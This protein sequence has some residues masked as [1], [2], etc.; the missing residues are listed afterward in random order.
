MT[1]G[2]RSA[3]AV[4]RAMNGAATDEDITAIVGDWRFAQVAALTPGIDPVVH[5]LAA[6][7][8]LLPSLMDADV[9]AGPVVQSFMLRLIETSAQRSP[10]RVR[11]MLQACAAAAPGAWSGDC[12]QAIVHAVHQNACDHAVAASLI[13]PCDRSARLLGSPAAA[14]GAVR[15]WG[16]AGDGATWTQELSE[17]MRRSVIDILRNAPHEMVH[18]L[19]W[20]PR[21][22]VESFTPP[23][24]SLFGAFDAFALASDPVRRAHASVIARLI[25][26]AGDDGLTV[27]ALVRFAHAARSDAAWDQV[28]ASMKRQPAI[29]AI[30]ASCAPWHAIPEPMRAWMLR[31]ES[32]ACTVIRLARTG[33]P[34]GFVPPNDYWFVH[35]FLAISAIS[36]R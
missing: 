3:E 27:S 25:Q 6:A 23:P 1:H 24:E 18:C 20:M 34:S 17:P 35:T 29:A 7:A 32:P 8:A 2:S 33:C 9:V 14:A 26:H 11:T 22:M 5:S 15:S 28:F 16:R 10:Q 30:V 36:T 13:G 31:N 4:V 19:P 12:A 21:E